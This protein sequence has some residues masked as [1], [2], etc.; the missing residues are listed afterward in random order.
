MM[1]NNEGTRPHLLL[2]SYFRSSCSA[3]VRT[4]AHLKNIPLEYEYIHL[5][6]NDQSSVNYLLTNPSASVP[7]LTVTSPSGG[8]IVI[9]QSVAILEF[10]EEYFPDTRK[11][12]PDTTDIVARAR[13]RELVNIV[14]TDIQPP[15]NLR[16]LNKVKTLSKSS[17]AA[18]E[19]AKDLM[20]AGLAAYD[21]VAEKYSGR[22]SVGDEITLA[23]IC[24]APAVEGALRYKVDIGKLSTVQKIY[25]NIRGIEEFKRGDWKHQ[26]DTPEEFKEQN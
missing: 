26:E 1:A 22:Y 12:L 8:Q 19:W 2:H 10:F 11:L 3:R 21:Q 15:T 13:V 7:T 14:A 25:N 4:A 18:T 5:L 24:L 9:R 20:F 17:D 23:D 6:K 16:I